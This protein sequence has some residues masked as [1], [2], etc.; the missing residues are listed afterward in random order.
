MDDEQKTN[1]P[2]KYGIVFEKHNEIIPSAMLMEVDELKIDNGGVNNI[3]IEGENLIALELLRNEY[4]NRIDTVCIDPPYNTGMSWLTYEDNDYVDGQ[5]NYSHSKWLSFMHNRLEIAYDLLSDKGIVFIN[6]DEH[7]IGTLL[8]LCHEMFGERNVDVLVWPKTDPRY[9]MNRI[10]KPFRDIKIV[11]EY[12]LVCFKDRDT[13]TIKNIMIPDFQ[14]GK[15]VDSP[16]TMETIIYG[17]GTTSSAKDEMEKI[18]GDRYIFQTPKPMRLYKE[19]IRAA[20]EPNSII[21]DFFA[22]SGT[23]GHAVMDLNSEDDGN[24]KFILI[25]NNE[26]NICRQITYARLKKAIDME[27]YPASIRYFTIK[28]QGG[29]MIGKRPES[30]R[31]EI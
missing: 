8:L 12:V 27:R 3:L 18:F 26:N 7:E 9:D 4:R 30:K 5:D 2:N 6:I 11:H 17:L 22:G 14:H 28:T 15:S 21:L 16:S 19:L 20:S 25:N 31:P 29:D 23:T 1:F 10:E 13:V 24:R